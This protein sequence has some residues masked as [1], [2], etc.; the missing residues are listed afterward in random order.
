MCVCVRVCACV[1]ERE[2]IGKGEGRI[3]WDTVSVL[4]WDEER[5]KGVNLSQCGGNMDLCLSSWPSC[6]VSTSMFGIFAP[7]CEPFSFI[8]PVH[9]DTI[10]LTHGTLALLTSTTGLESSVKI[11]TLLMGDTVVTS[12][13]SFLFESGYKFSVPLKG[14]VSV[15]VVMTRKSNTI[16]NFLCNILQCPV[17]LTCL[18]TS[19]SSTTMSTLKPVDQPKPPSWWFHSL[20]L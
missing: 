10:D 18:K 13:P 14:S 4:V 12:L 8:P 11:Q 3:G 20:K 5:T 7:K 16:R 19:L 17:V 15:E 6:I 1:R 2:R 9:I